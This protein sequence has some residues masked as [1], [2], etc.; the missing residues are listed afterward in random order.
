MSAD[1]SLVLNSSDEE[2]GFLIP[3]HAVV[4]GDKKTTSSIFIFDPKTSTVKKAQIKSSV[5][6][7]NN[8]VVTKGIKPGV[9]VAIAGVSY[10]KD[11]QKVKL[12]E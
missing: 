3:Y 10:L 2:A 11:G 5:S 12:M 6:K 4:P 8:I 7:G 1:V 9:I